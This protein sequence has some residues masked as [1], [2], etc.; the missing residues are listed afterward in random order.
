M[1]KL[2]LIASTA[3]VSTLLLQSAAWAAEDVLP[4]RK[5]LEGGG[6]KVTW[7]AS[8]Q[9]ASFT[10]ANGV[11]GSVT[12]GNKEY[13]LD[14]KKGK[15]GTEV[16]LVDGS[17]IA[18]AELFKAINEAGKKSEDKQ[19]L[20]TVVKVKADAETGVVESGSDAADDPA[21][22]VHPTDASK[23]KIIATNKGGGVL[24]YDLNGKQVQSYTI[25]KMNNI[26]VR[27]GLPLG[28]GKVDIAA[29]TNRT[30]N[31]IDVF[32]INPDT[33]A[34]TSIVDK[35][36][37]SEMGEVYGF[38]LYHSKRTDKFYALVL[39]KKGEFEQYE[40]KDNGSGKVE[41]KKVRDYKFETQ[42]EGLV[43]DDEYGVMYLA[44][45]DVAIWKM[46]AEP[47]GDNKAVKVAGVDDKALTA[48][49]EGLTIYYAADGKGYLLASSQGSSTYAVYKREGKNEYIGNF[50]IVDSD[51]IDG[52]TET[53]G[54]DV[55]GFGLG[56]AYP[57]GLF[58]T[59]DDE[60]IENGVK[61][62]QN[63][64]MVAWDKIAKAFKT[65]LTVDNTVNPRQFVKRELK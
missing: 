61:V 33:G 57:N 65:P 26:D 63:F 60:N 46:S 54:I 41:G 27:Y 6:A 53:D 44:E 52:T 18:P 4:L 21:I 15:L 14:G 11:K 39:G 55:V 8:T 59:Q 37:K 24:V 42:A 29:A 34:L 17:T 25:G 20:S 2:K 47:D 50:S 38:S 43:A 48:D 1:K 19:P 32:S 36:I 28:S 23:S 9:T 40:L 3:L 62:N 58:V 35:P 31:T 7:E 10:L 16:K 64:K 30:T 22:W 5:Q 49:I 56:S 13:V 45:E 51:K 12:V